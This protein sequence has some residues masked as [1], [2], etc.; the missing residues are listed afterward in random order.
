MKITCRFIMCCSRKTF[1]VV[2]KLHLSQEKHSP[3]SIFVLALNLLSEIL[4][5]LKKLLSL[6]SSKVILFAVVTD[7]TCIPM[8]YYPIPSQPGQELFLRPSGL[9]VVGHFTL[10]KMTYSSRKRDGL[11]EFTEMTQSRCLSDD[12]ASLSVLS[13]DVNM[14]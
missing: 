8:G 5:K 6:W 3:S 10:S 9:L 1:D 14:Q 12:T 11:N 4:S 13:N 7:D 2:L